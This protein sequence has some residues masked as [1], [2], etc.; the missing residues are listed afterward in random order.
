VGIRPAFTYMEST[1]INVKVF[2]KT[3]SFLEQTKAIIAVKNTF[4]NILMT[5]LDTETKK[6]RGMAFVWKIT[7]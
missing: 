3:N 5:V 6:A 7:S 1:R 4:T 2:R